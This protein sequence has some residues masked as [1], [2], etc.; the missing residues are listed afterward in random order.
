[1]QPP[2]LQWQLRKAEP[3]GDIAARYF[4]ADGSAVLGPVHDRVLAVTL[5]D[6]AAIPTV[7]G[8]AYGRVKAPGVLG[9]LRGRL[10]DVLVCDESL[11]HAVLAA[12]PSNPNPGGRP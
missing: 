6:L 2:V 7:V 1:M 8:L 11:A 4:D 3:V 10:I 12:A 9:A 5:D